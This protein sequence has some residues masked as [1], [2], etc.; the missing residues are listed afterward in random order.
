M[1]WLIAPFALAAAQ[2]PAP[3]AWEG[4]ATQGGLLRGQV[5]GDVVALRL[6]AGAEDTPAALADGRFMIGLDRDAPAAA[7]LVATL[8]DGAEVEV[9]LAVAP[10]AW[11]I[12]RVN[13]PYRPPNFDT[14]RPAELARIAAA[15]ARE[16]D[17]A[18]WLQPMWWPIGGPIRGLFGAQRIYR[19]VPGGYHGGIDIAAPT[20]AVVRAPAAGRVTLAADPPFTLEGRLLLIDH[21]G[22]LGS[23][24]MHLSRIDV[25]EGQQV[26]AGQPV[27]AAGATGRATG[28]H[29]HWGLTWRGAR[30]DPLLVAGPPPAR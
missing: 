30:L 17:A 13:A 25:A 20:G 4:N 10:R 1:R 11:R 8:R 15:R 2:A 26:A 16:T 12:E 18:G 24:L 6:R 29:L 9:P 7:T 5:R 28:P 22:G 27:G 19:G 14:R 23:A 3:V 21:G